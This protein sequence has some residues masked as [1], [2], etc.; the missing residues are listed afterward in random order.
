VN[1]TFPMLNIKMDDII[2]SWAG[3]RPLIHQEGKSASELSRKD[4]IF[5]SKTGLISIAGGKLS[6]YRKMAERVVNQFCSKPC[7]TKNLL[8]SQTTNSDLSYA[9]EHEWVEYLSDYAVRRTGMLYFEPE[10]L[11]STMDEL[12][13]CLAT[14]KK[15]STTRKEE[16]YRNLKQIINNTVNFI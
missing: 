6:G 7:I 16:E 4:E 12:L 8:L 5:I 1:Q 14:K 9:I 2:S 10:K 15:W 11:K 3:L 13:D